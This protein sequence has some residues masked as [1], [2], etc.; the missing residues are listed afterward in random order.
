MNDQKGFSFYL[1][2]GK[3]KGCGFHK[4]GPSRR[5]CLGFMSICVAKI[6]LESLI[7][8][9]TKTSSGIDADKT[10]LEMREKSVIEKEKEVNSKI[11]KL[12]EEFEAKRIEIDKTYT[13]EIEIL[14][15]DYPCKEDLE[16]AVKDAETKASDLEAKLQPIQ[17]KLDA[18]EM[19]MA[20]LK[21]EVSDLEDQNGTLEAENTQLKKACN[22]IIQAVNEI[23]EI[24]GIEL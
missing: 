24:D 7:D 11:D 22:S 6:D 9:A 1:S 17:E 16:K 3:G 4:D 8:W 23:N 21:N 15:Q 20:D 2:F 14:K 13:D 10:I 18:A 19:D 5:L 12:K